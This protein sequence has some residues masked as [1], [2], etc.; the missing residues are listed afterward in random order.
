MPE[1]EVFYC[2]SILNTSKFYGLMPEKIKEKTNYNWA[3]R[4]LSEL[5]LYSNEEPN[6]CKISEES[7]S[8]ELCSPV[9]S[10]D[11]SKKSNVNS[12]GNIQEGMS[13]AYS[14]I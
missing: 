13:H 3:T 9:V 4:Y 7:S 2:L 1:A 10:L 14:E 8:K 11:F 12:G 5:V 6:L